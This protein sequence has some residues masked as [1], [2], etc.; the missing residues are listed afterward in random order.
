MKGFLV[1]QKQFAVLRDLLEKGLKSTPTKF[2][3]T[4]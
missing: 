3:D 4:P 1:P 2:L